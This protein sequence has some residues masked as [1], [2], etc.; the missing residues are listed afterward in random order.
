M[1]QMFLK[2]EPKTSHKRA[3]VVLVVGGAP[4]CHFVLKMHTI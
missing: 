4:F 2:S 1:G 3:I